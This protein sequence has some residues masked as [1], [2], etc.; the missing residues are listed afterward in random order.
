VRGENDVTKNWLRWTLASLALVVAANTGWACD[1]QAQNADAKDKDGK[2]V[3]GQADAKG[4][5]M[6]CCAHA[7]DTAGAKTAEGVAADKPCAGHDPKGCP[8]KAAL[9]AKTEAVK[10]MPAADANAATQR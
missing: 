8:K 9:V 10:D 1:A 2:V 7:H 4:C 5:D 3:S 6:P